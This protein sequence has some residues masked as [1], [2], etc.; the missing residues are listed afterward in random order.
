M[1][2]ICNLSIVP[3]RKNPSNASEIVTQLLFGEHF[4]ILESTKEG[5]ARILTA[6]DKYECWINEKQFAPISFKTFEHLEK[7]TATLSNELIAL[8]HKKNSGVYFPLLIGSVLPQYKNGELHFE[9]ESFHFEG[10]VVKDGDRKR[11]DEIIS[12]ARQFLEA[13]YLWG[14]KS[15]FGID[16]SGFTQLVFR[17]NG[18]KLPRDAYQQVEAGETL[19][20]VEEAGAGDLAFFDN[21]AGKIVHVGIVMENQRIIHAHGKVRIDPFDHHGIYNE[22]RKKYTHNLRVIKS[23]VH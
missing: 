13:P 1:Y 3:C 23:V 15:I 18:F 16:C 6:Y 5:W 11:P 14:G 22:E 7:E 20:F 21:E 9:K 8:L 2:G 17:L 19:S 12:C 10:T 4:S